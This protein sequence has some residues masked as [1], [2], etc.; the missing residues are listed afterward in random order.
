MKLYQTENQL[1]DFLRWMPY[2][3]KEV[4]ALD[5]ETYSIRPGHPQGGLL[6]SVSRIRLIQLATA[7]PEDNPKYEVYVLDLMCLSDAKYKAYLESFTSR[8]GNLTLVGHNSSFDMKH[9]LHHTPLTQ[10]NM[11]CTQT[12]FYILISALDGNPHAYKADLGKLVEYFFDEKLPKELQKSDWSA[13]ELSK[14]QLEYAVNDVIW[15]RKLYFALQE[16]LAELDLLEIVELEDALRPVLVRMSVKGF[17]INTELHDK[18]SAE[19]KERTEIAEKECINFLN[20]EVIE[21]LTSPEALLAK[22]KVNHLCLDILDTLELPDNAYDLQ[23]LA[24]KL[25]ELAEQD[26]TKLER[27]ALRRIAKNIEERLIT[28][29]K[30]KR[31]GAWLEERLSPQELEEW[32]KTE[33]SGDLSI[34]KEAFDQFSYLPF[35][36]PLAAYSD[37]A[38]LHSTYGEG[39]KQFIVDGRMACNF[40]Q[41]YAVTGR[42]SSSQPNIQNQPS[43]GSGKQLRRVFISSGE[44]RIL[45]RADL[46]QIELRCAAITSGDTTMLS[47]YENGMDLHTMTAM[48]M[49]GK[50]AGDISDIERTQAKI[51]NFALLYGAGAKSLVKYAWN[52]YKVLLTL[53]Q[54]ED[55][56]RLFRETY[57][58][59][60]EWQIEVSQEAE[61]SLC[62]TTPLGRYRVLPSDQYYTTSMNQPIQG[63]AGEVMK[64]ALIY[65]DREITLMPEESGDAYLV[66]TVHDEV[67]VDSAIEFAERNAEVIERCM[68]QAMLDVFPNACLNNL[69][70]VTVGRNWLQAK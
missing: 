23:Q 4:I 5:T 28:P 44:Y 65:M 49:T 67:I 41:G 38:K 70:E 46:N 53:P 36:E 25:Y 33:K 31:I 3:G 30:N 60:R 10:F 57:S 20:E 6:P 12:M 19:W 61:G 7:D 9:L 51:I 16:K 15:T 68:K 48:S 32:P 1:N 14:E 63:G 39:M 64:L 58:R 43:R 35:M 2:L 59:Y 62:T 27:T 26:R 40:K 13:P 22:V 55:Y 29:S 34:N 56:V 18:L 69:V 45:L 52:L 11:F 37:M 21:Q 8:L 24:V 17:H 54:A 47:A 42:L 50:G 66:T